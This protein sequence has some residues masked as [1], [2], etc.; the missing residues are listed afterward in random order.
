MKKLISL[1]LCLC[2]AAGVAAAEA[3]SADAA[4]TVGAK[5]I[6]SGLYGT[7]AGMG[8]IR[9]QDDF[10]A[11]VNREW[12][13]NTQIPAG[14]S[15]ISSREELDMKNT[16]LKIE[17]LSGGKKDDPE[18]TA[19]QN[20]YAMLT[21]WEMRNA[22]GYR[23]LKTYTDQIM[24]ISN[25]DELTEYLGDPDRNLYGSPMT[26][27][28]VMVN[29]YDAE[30]YIM[31]VFPPALLGAADP[32]LYAEGEEGTMLTYYRQLSQY[33]LTRLD[34]SETEAVEIFDRCIGF[35]RN[36]RQPLTE[37]LKRNA[38]KGE[39]AGTW[40]PV[41][42]DDLDRNLVNFPLRN[43]YRSLGIELEGLVSNAAPE[44]LETLDSLYTNEH[45]EELKAWVLVWTLLKLPEHMDRETSEFSAKVSAP[46]TGAG[47]MLP[48]DQYA[49]TNLYEQYKGIIDKLFA[50]YCFDPEVKAQV[51]ELTR[52]MISAYRDM[53]QEEDWLSEETK[54][55]A[56]E[57][58]DSIRI[59]V[60]YPDQMPDFTDVVIASKEEGGSILQA[61]K[62]VNRQILKA[63]NE[64]LHAKN[65]GT[66]WYSDVHYSK[67][68]ACYLP[69]DNSINIS[70]GIC[71]GDYFDASWPLE[72]KLGGL[73]MVVGHEITH[74]FDTFGAEFDKDGNYRDWW[75]PEDKEAFRQRVDRM[76]AYY[77]KLVPVPQVSDKPYGENGARFIEGEAIADLGS[78]KC[79]LSIAKQQENFDYRTFFTQIAT[80]QKNVRYEAAE[81]NY[82]ATNN[83]PVECYRCNI[84]VQNYDEFL[85][86]FDVR[87]GDGMYL[88]PEDR[89]RVW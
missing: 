32:S 84:P 36:F 33:M 60:C 61:Y 14:M 29:P 21:D 40:N 64:L 31:Y 44:C 1:F 54:A 20:Y 46:I 70:A 65:D 71:G 2:L 53:L 39:T 30:N 19:M 13:E 55:A 12:A 37:Y 88:A 81:M 66:F 26:G 25:V 62:A 42:I 76:V 7:F 77:S 8:E 59:H 4:R 86:T 48:D 38:Q 78:M 45:I 72:K 57:K 43:L 49:Y 28:K 51:T 34:Y 50:E 74:A 58:L 67:L 68:E 5:W 11:W 83:H 79:L 27:G 75:K 10:A 15:N 35:E 73:C 47:S 22:T 69:S 9:P 89:I 23:E 52:M 6:D 17:L 16:A 41:T 3:E 56:I 63:E 87:E 82:L 24:A 80:I 85:E 18:L